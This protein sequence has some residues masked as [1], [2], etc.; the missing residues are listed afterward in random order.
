MS[1]D[2]DT[3]IKPLPSDSGSKIQA[4]QGSV[5]PK[6]NQEIR[7]QRLPPKTPQRP[8]LPASADSGISLTIDAS[9]DG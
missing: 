8:P 7:A 5:T 6:K 4:T 9:D 2:E 1:A 3:P